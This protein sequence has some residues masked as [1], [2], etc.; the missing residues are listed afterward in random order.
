MRLRTWILPLLISTVH[1]LPAHAI[2]ER[3]LHYETSPR[4]GKVIAIRNMA[5]K[6][7]PAELRR[8]AGAAS[9]LS[10]SARRF[11]GDAQAASLPVSDVE[12]LSHAFGVAKPTEELRLL[13]SHVDTE[14]IAHERYR[15][16]VRGVPV[17]GGEI[18]VHRNERG[19]LTSMSGNI[20]T[21][22]GIET[23]PKVLP[24]RA[25]K[26]ALRNVER[27]GSYSL[28]HKRALVEVRELCRRQSPSDSRCFAK[29]RK[30]VSK[31]L[32]V[33][34]PKLHFRNEGFLRNNS[35]TATRLVYEVGVS[36][37]T[38]PYAE[39]ILIDARS[40][41]IVS[42]R[43]A[44]HGMYREIWDCSDYFDED[45]C[46]LNGWVSYY[47]YY[48]G[49]KEGEPVRG[50]NPMPPPFFGTTDVDYQYDL[51]PQVEAY[52]AT[53]FDRDGGNGRGG[54]GDGIVKPF[55]T[56]RIW[57][58][59][60]GVRPDM[61]V[62]L[63]AW[64]Y[65][66]GSIATCV[67]MPQIHD[68]FGHEYAHAVTHFLSFN[69]DNSYNSLGIYWESG[70]LMEHYSDLMG[71]SFERYMTG[72]NDWILFND[73]SY[74]SFVRPIADPPSALDL[75]LATIDPPAIPY[76]DR[77]HSPN[78]Y[79]GTA[80][81]GGIHHN[82]TVPSK[83]AYLASEGGI[84]NGCTIQGIGFDKVEQIWYRA[85]TQYFTTS[86]TFNMAYHS[87]RNACDDLY[88]PA[89]C[90]EVTK[91][92]QAV[93]LDQPGAC[94]GLPALPPACGGACQLTNS[95]AAI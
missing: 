32:L 53:K 67:G 52:Y 18:L 26:I 64:F 38:K 27:R 3:S 1:S 43:P 66:D 86:E 90:E 40:K 31:R 56:T 45:L 92:L 14:G 81:A 75:D 23:K 48:F 35:E 89:D 41:K 77:F 25:T 33:S 58:N 74:Q 85:V 19:E 61:C 55:G 5:A 51:V 11:S 87:F 34:T 9:V 63:G 49:R 84:F 7:T 8:M 70:A 93:E 12:Q 21:S 62:T 2:D 20:L 72:T 29:G 60:N 91:A 17:L 95:F 4:T 13:S 54:I 68:L 15:Q 16:V 44:R 73:D 10:P 69:P 82:S 80:D 71:E 57:A 37:K 76:P 42:R 50:P 28:M 46:M 79:C 22:L 47:Q 24:S 83:A 88:S 65:W 6:R 36:L 78:Y 30:S 39:S 94:S 59:T